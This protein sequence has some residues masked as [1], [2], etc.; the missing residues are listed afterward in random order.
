MKKLGLSVL[1][2][3]A[4]LMCIPATGSAMSAEEFAR[5]YDQLEKIDIGGALRVQYNYKDWDDA[6]DE[7]VG[8]FSFDTF[9]FNLDGEIGDM[10]L[11]AEYRFYP[12]YDFHCPHHGWVGYNFNENW[13]GQIGVHQ[14]PFGIQPYASHNFWFSGAYYNGFEDDYDMG[15]KALYNDG[16]WDWA[17]AFY[18]NEE[19]GASDP[20]RYSVD[21]LNSGNGNEETNQGNIRCAYTFTHDENNSTEFGLSG[22]Y[23]QLYNTQTED[24]GD[25]Y[26]GAAHIVG[27][28]GN[29]NIQ[30]EGI[31]YEYDPENPEGAND[32]AITV[33]AYSF[34]WKAP[35]EATMGIANIAYTL[36]VDIG[37]ISSLTFYSD[38]TIIEPDND[39]W[40][41]TWQ[42]VV[43][44]LVAAGPVY[45]YIDVISAENMTF[46]G[47]SMANNLDGYQASNNRNTRLNINVGYYF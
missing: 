1:F 31:Q 6:Q 29:W 13:Q 22:Q 5:M 45:T 47:G 32:D 18:K 14:V 28:Y 12:E 21:V 17:F 34:A 25:G 40:D 26:A 38:N 3:A 9:R 20:G 44:C 41:T 2:L 30:L 37:P 39:D 16:P 27:N 11:S 24:T 19:F 43:G 15:I 10:I 46:M 36:P 7:K 8:D 35:S 42:N 4:F 33:G 23:G